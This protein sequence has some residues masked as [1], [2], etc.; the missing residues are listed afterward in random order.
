MRTGTILRLY[1]EQGRQPAP[2]E[3]GQIERDLNALEDAKT[4]AEGIFNG[5]I[6]IDRLRVN[7]LEALTPLS[8]V[9]T[10]TGGSPATINNASETEIEFSDTRGYFPNK[11]GYACVVKAGGTNKRFTPAPWVQEKHPIVIFGDFAF[12]RADSGIREVYLNFYDKDDAYL[13]SYTFITAPHSY[14]TMNTITFVIQEW[15]AFGDYCTL[16]VYQ[17]GGTALDLMSA[18]FSFMLG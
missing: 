5:T 12:E 1:F 18:N 13:G 3:F 14:N 11:E 17:N 15:F 7:G 2:D 16:S 9:V 6:T 8:H 4:R 10:Y